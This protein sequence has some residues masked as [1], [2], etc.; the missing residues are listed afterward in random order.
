MPGW[1]PSTIT[2]DPTIASKYHRNQDQ[3]EE[4]IEEVGMLRRELRGGKGYRD[5]GEPFGEADAVAL[6][7][8]IAILQQE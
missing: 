3:A 5:N 1:L 7:K 6:K 8:Q 2:A 4:L